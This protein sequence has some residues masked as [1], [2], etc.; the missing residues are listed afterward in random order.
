MIT[1]CDVQAKLDALAKPMGSLGQLE[2]RA[3]K[4]AVAGQS[5]TPATRPRRVIL[6]ATDHGTLLK[7]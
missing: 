6:F 1:R 2:A 7:G 5:L 3:V 4:L